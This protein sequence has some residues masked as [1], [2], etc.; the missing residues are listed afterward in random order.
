MRIKQTIIASLIVTGLALPTA[1]LAH[2]GE[3]HS[4][5]KPASASATPKDYTFITPVNGSLSELVRKALQSY[6]K[7]NDKI[8]LTPAQALAAEVA[9]VQQLGAR[10]LEVNEQI[11]IPASVLQEQTTKALALDAAT[12]SEWQIYA[13][14]TDFDTN[15]VKAAV[16][17]QPA[18]VPTEP[19]SE[20]NSHN[21]SLNNDKDASSSDD[22]RNSS[23]WLLVPVAVALLALIISRNR[24]AASVA[25]KSNAQTKKTQ[26][27]RSKQTPR[28]RK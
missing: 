21:K 6:D 17:A 24:Q 15:H 2:D 19:E 3:D 8:S 1:V 25:S 20:S 7:D 5:D 10:L 26:P 4:S 9:V 16:A 12:L 14:G 23:L 22:S 13:A 27:K 28:R 11:S 18:A